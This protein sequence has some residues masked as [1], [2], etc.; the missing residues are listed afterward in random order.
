L[1][2]ASGFAVGWSARWRS[3]LRPRAVRRER[4]LSIRKKVERAGGE[5]P[6]RRKM[7]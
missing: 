4:A 2:L 1:L 3:H 6:R 5:G 7:D